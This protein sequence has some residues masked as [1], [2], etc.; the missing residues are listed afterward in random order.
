MNRVDLGLETLIWTMALQHLGRNGLLEAVVDLWKEAAPPVKQT[1]EYLECA[2]VGQA[3]LDV[4]RDAQKAV[5][6]YVPFRQGTP[7]QVILYSLH[8]QHLSHG[9]MHRLPINEL[10]RPLQILVLENDMGV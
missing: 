9:L 10:P 1:V 7:H 4:V 2:R 3:V 8:A 5:G 6:A